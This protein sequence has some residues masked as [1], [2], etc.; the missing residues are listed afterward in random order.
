[1]AASSGDKFWYARRLAAALCYVGLV[2]LDTIQVLPFESK[3]H[4]GKAVG[5]GQAPLPAGF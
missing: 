3:L 1:M 2:R 4:E 5:G